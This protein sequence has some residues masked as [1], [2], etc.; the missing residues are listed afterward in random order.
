MSY[1]FNPISGLSVDPSKAVSVLKFL[2]IHVRR[3]FANMPV[4][5]PVARYWWEFYVGRPSVRAS[6]SLVLF[7]DDNLNIYQLI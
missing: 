6:I 4:L 1:E 5:Y 7:L 3:I 2:F